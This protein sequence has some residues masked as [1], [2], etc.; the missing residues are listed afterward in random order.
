[1]ESK[2]E[3]TLIVVLPGVQELRYSRSRMSTDAYVTEPVPDADL[4]SKARREQA[5]G[6]LFNRY[7][8][9]KDGAIDAVEM[10]AMLCELLR[11]WGTAAE[12]KDADFFCGGAGGVSNEESSLVKRSLACT[13]EDAHHLLRVISKS[14]DNGDVATSSEFALWVLRAE[15]AMQTVSRKRTRES[16]ERETRMDLHARVMLIAAQHIEKPNALHKPQRTRSRTTRAGSSMSV[17]LAA[18]A[19]FGGNPILYNNQ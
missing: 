10:E 14:T 16:D 4:P 19:F 6:I 2:K 11:L 8:T 7:D 12:I 17:K 3:T 9:D 15:S 1:M 5:L 18:G 13:S